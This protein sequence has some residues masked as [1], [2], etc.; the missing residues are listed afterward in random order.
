MSRRTQN[1]RM[2]PT[3][4][5]RVGESNLNINESQIE[6]AVEIPGLQRL[7]T[8]EQLQPPACRPTMLELEFDVW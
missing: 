2:A 7:L 5:W 6:N 4:F 1:T 3:G 8:R